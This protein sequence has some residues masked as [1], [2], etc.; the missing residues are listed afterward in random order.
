M[1]N[2]MTFFDQTAGD[3]VELS[4][5]DKKKVE[6]FKKQGMAEETRG[7]PLVLPRVN[8]LHQGSAMFQ[9]EADGTPVKAF[10]AVI[11]HVEPQRAW[12]RYRY[13]TPESKSGDGFPDCYSRDLYK[14]DVGSRQKQF[15]NCGQCPNDKFGSD[16]LP[17]GT[18]GRG[19][20]CKEVRRLFFIM[21]GHVAPHWMAIP[22]TS[23][24]ALRSYF[25]LLKDKKVERPQ[26]AITNFA[27]K[28]AENAGGVEYSELT[29]SFV[30]ELPA[31]WIPMI[32]ASKQEI[33]RLL[34]T[35]API[36]QGEYHNQ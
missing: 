4:P 7:L 25:T 11:V 17:D 8:M 14:P 24:K 2:D 29:L 22:P 6:E 10:N 18:Q 27:L 12:W 20:A 26:L 35:A 23:L 32:M 28:T 31:P 33:E 9:L 36:S 16:V 15:D 21:E 5:E 19:K 34:T 3:F 13:G 30:K 1:A